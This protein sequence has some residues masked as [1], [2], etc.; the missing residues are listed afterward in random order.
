[1]VTGGGSCG[2]SKTGSVGGSEGAGRA[3]LD[4]RE[5]DGC[6]AGTGGFLR[7]DEA[8]GDSGAGAG[9][10]ADARAVGLGTVAAGVFFGGAGS[11]TGGSTTGGVRGDAGDAAAISDATGENGTTSVV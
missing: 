1:V 3:G 5:G 7:L 11:V 9:I 10:F 4:S 8:A 2:A 6:A